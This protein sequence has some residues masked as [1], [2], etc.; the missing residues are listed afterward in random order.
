MNMEYAHP[1]L[2][3]EAHHQ[4][5][6]ELQAEVQRDR[7][8]KQTRIRARMLRLSLVLENTPSRLTTS[9]I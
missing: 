5:G 6:K 1:E 8:G 9:E 7:Q 2:L 4:K 3:L